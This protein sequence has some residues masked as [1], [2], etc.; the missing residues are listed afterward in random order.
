MTM[1]EEHDLV[2]GEWEDPRK[3]TVRIYKLTPR[4]EQELSRLKAIVQPKL[5][6]AIEVL[7]KFASDLTGDNGAPDYI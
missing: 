7:Q 3:R 4:G 2:E 1:L 5:E 6:E